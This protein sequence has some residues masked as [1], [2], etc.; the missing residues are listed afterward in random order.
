MNAFDFQS[1]FDIAVSNEVSWADWETESKTEQLAKRFQ[2]CQYTQ[3][4][5]EKPGIIQRQQQA[6]AMAAHC[7]GV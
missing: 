1:L 3:C 4:W 6:T 2:G 7:L 5:Y